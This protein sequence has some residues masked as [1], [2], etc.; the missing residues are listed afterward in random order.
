[1]ANSHIKFTEINFKIE[2]GLTHCTV[3]W[4]S[5]DPILCGYG[6]K[7]SFP[8]TM[9]IVDIIPLIGNGVLTD[10]RWTILR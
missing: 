2:D 8:A 5:D 7:R 4:E 1:M 6:A 9:P 10:E 3:R